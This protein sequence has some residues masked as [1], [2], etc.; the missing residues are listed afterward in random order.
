M[1]LLS[2]AILLFVFA[3]TPLPANGAE[4][5]TPAKGSPERKEILDTLRRHLKKEFNIDAVFFVE[6][7]K[8][9]N[10]W[11]W[12]QVSPRSPDGKNFYEPLGVLVRLEKGKWQIVDF[13]PG[14]CT[15]D[16]DDSPD[17]NPEVFFRKLESKFK[18]PREIFP[19]P[20]LK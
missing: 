18:T 16:E 5:Y 2:L 6:H 20:G 19:V 1:K 8:I 15:G 3:L 9:R 14:E 10:E 17:C 7:F 11:A 13:A 12:L 4:T